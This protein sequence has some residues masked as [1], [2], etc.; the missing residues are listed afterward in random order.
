MRRAKKKVMRRVTAVVYDHSVHKIDLVEVMADTVYD[1]ASSTYRLDKAAAE[2]MALSR[3]DEKAL[4]GDKSISGYLIA[5][6][7][8]MQRMGQITWAT[9]IEVTPTEEIVTL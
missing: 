4:K 3:I 6:Q 1:I 8:D 5:N 9:E 7:D 2:A